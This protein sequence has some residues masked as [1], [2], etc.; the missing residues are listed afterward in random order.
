MADNEQIR[1]PSEKEVVVESTERPE[2]GPDEVLVETKRTLVSTGTELMFL[3]DSHP[4]E[5][6]SLPFEPGYNNLGEVIE[7]G[8]NVDEDAL[9]A[10]VASYGNHQAYTTGSLDSYYSIP[11]GVDDDE[12][13]FFTIAEIVMNG[14]RRG[15]LAYGETAAIYGLGLLGQFA[16]RLSHLA[17]AH[18]VVGLDLAADRIGHLPDLPG[19]VGLNPREDD[20]FDHFEAE[21]GGRLADVVFEVTGVGNAIPDQ[22]EALREGGRF[23]VLG[24][25]RGSCE[26]DFNR[27]C[28]N[29]GYTIVGAHNRTHPSHPSME[30]P[31]TRPRHVELFFELLDGDRLSVS[32]L[33]THRESY[34]DAPEV[35]EML[36][37]DRTRALGV[38]LEWD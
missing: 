22:F 17:G 28:H 15:E 31:W 13:V 16:V 18:P 34:E 10:R 33:I 30:N 7:V 4:G 23:V 35:Y 19:V 11:A 36:L 2:P 12:A 24:S 26:F 3:T 8:A 5:G 1:F 20:W 21:T 25:P 29:P 27:S 37:E 38:V 9:G 6:T 14:L 32:D